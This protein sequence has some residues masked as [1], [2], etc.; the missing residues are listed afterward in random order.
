MEHAEVQADAARALL[1]ATGSFT[2]V[3]TRADLTGRPRM[4]VG[5]RAARDVAGSTS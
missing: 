3:E 2:A 1:E 4:V 5:R